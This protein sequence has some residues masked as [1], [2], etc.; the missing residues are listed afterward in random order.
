MVDS[1]TEIRT[2]RGSQK[3]C[4]HTEVHSVANA[5]DE[6]EVSMIFLVVTFCLWVGIK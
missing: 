1:L 2:E 4:K 5:I 6:T 3:F